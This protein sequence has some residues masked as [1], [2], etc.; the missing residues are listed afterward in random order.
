MEGHVIE[1]VDPFHDQA[2]LA[3]LGMAP[4]HLGDLA[5]SNEQAAHL[6]RL[7]GAPE[8]AGE[9]PIGPPAGAD[10]GQERRQVAG[11]EA[12]QRIVSIECGHHHLTDLA[13]GYRIAGARAHDLHQHALII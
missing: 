9:A 3:H 12:N 10:A 2:R 7:I 11:R 6:G 13:K 4:D 8:P 1:V 5:R